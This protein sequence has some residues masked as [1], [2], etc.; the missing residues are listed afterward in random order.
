M[1]ECHLNSL[2]NFDVPDAE[3]IFS[4]MCALAHAILTQAKACQIPLE[5]I[6]PNRDLREV[7]E[8]CEDL[9]LQERKG[10]NMFAIVR[11]FVESF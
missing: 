3:E 11:E 1:W 2:T 6:V 4:E 9:H 5:K 10:C 8:I 7:L